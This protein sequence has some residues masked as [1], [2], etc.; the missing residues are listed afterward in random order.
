MLAKMVTSAERVFVVADQTKLGRRALASFGNVSAWG[1]L[2]TDAPADAEIVKQLVAL[3]VK[4]NFASE[5]KRRN[6]REAV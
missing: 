6:R 1:G 3:G 4:M 2:I 5:L